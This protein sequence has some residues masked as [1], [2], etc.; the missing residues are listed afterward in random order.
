MKVQ[1][2]SLIDQKPLLNEILLETSKR[3]V[4]SN[5]PT[6][7]SKIMTKEKESRSRTRESCHS[8]GLVK[9]LLHIWIIY[10]V[11]PLK[12]IYFFQTPP[13]Y[14]YFC[15]GGIPQILIS[16]PSQVFVHAPL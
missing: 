3:G 15:L 8:C 14:L 5:I 11:T 13:F 2:L 10:F 6:R 4:H 16:L 1:I 12:N 7:E 9:P